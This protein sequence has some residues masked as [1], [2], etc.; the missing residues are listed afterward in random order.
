MS[1]FSRSRNPPWLDAAR[2]FCRT[3]NI[4]IMGSGSHALIVEAK[5]PE[6]AA[7]VSTQ[8]AS[9]GFQPVPDQTTTT[10]AS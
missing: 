1:L 6:R 5:F 3:R 9:L 2:E 4:T 8:L 7:E 10:P